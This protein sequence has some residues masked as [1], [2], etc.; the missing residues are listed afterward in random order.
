M[1]HAVRHSG[2][3]LTSLWSPFYLRA[4]FPSPPISFLHV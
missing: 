2:Q 3:L 1:E 4:D